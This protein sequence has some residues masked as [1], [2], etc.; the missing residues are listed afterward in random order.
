SSQPVRGRIAQWAGEGVVEA[1]SPHAELF[2]A[3]GHKVKAG[4]GRKTQG[5][6]VV[7]HAGEHVVGSKLPAGRD[8]AVLNPERVIAL[9]AQGDVEVRVL[10]HLVRLLAGAGAAYF[11]FVE[12][13]ILQGSDRFDHLRIGAE[14]IE[15]RLRQRHDGA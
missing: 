4:A 7:G 9:A 10:G 2:L 12:D 15:V 13:E 11:R 3:N 8:D 6:V 1:V 14:V 5:P